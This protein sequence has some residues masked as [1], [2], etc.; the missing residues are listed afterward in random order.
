MNSSKTAIVISGIIEK[1]QLITGIVIT[2]IF[3]IT[4][5]ACIGD[6]KYPIEE[7]FTMF[8]FTAIGILLIIFS[9]KRKKLIK[10]FKSY[11]QRLSVDPTSSIENL[12]SGLGTS[13]DVVKMNLEKMIKKRYFSNA[14][15]DTENN[16]IVFSK[17]SEQQTNTI[18]VNQSNEPKIEYITV[19]CKSCGGINKI[20]K[21]TVGECEYC[22]SPLS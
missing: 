12:A 17:A 11:V 8:V 14:Y 13:Q 18:K 2:F 7:K 22:G 10:N 6:N 16:R 5:I 20:A 9:I 4:A 15:I 3:G 1:V 21:G 19:T